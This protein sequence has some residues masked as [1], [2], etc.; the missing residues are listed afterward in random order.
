MPVVGTEPEYLNSK[1]EL[2]KISVL[3]DKGIIE[4]IELLIFKPENIYIEEENP[5][6]K[7][8]IKKSKYESLETL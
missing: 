4:S 6:S 7:F 1:D 3:T 5:L 8:D 2:E